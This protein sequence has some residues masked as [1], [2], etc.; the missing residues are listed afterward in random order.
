M[1]ILD[2]QELLD[3]ARMD[4]EGALPVDQIAD[5]AAEQ[6][7]D[8]PMF[9]GLSQYRRDDLR[10]GIKQYLAQEFGRGAISDD[11]LAEIGEALG[12]CEKWSAA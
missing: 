7:A 2:S 11:S 1:N 9:E 4:W 12:L 6:I 10:R 8:L 3:D 5:K